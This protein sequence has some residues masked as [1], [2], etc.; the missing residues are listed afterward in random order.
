MYENK[1][2]D[3]KMY[4]KLMLNILKL[5]GRFTVYGL[6]TPYLYPIGELVQGSFHRGF[7]T[8]IDQGSFLKSF[9]TIMN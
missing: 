2:Y 4:P 9:L 5:M 6:G 7:H 8:C 1:V 3:R